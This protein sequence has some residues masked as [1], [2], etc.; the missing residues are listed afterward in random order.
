[1]V[2][3]LRYRRSIRAQEANIRE[4]EASSSYRIRPTN[5]Q[6]V[7]TRALLVDEEASQ[8]FNAQTLQLVASAQL[9]RTDRRKDHERRKRVARMTRDELK[10]ELLT[11][12]LTGLPN[13]RALDERPVKPQ[14]LVVIDVDGL[15]WFNDELG[16]EAGDQL[17]RAVAQ[18]LTWAGVE[19]F[20]IHGDEFYIVFENPDDIRR[21]MD[22]IQARLLQTAFGIRD[23]QARA[24][25]FM[26]ACLSWGNGHTVDA[27]TDR[28]QWCKKMRERT[29]V[30]TGKRGG[31][32]PSVQELN[33][34][35]RPLSMPWINFT[36][37]N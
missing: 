23:T 10:R 30:R 18:T 32:P 15:K 1:M 28:L 35:L 4:E 31:M 2:P 8:M 13:A 9:V 22:D 29:G 33:S 11:D 37:V 21:T 34:D 25:I 20:R 7:I 5:K 27:A 24:R 36:I 12:H 19:A 3:R 17:L 26:G 14:H 6:V 16:H